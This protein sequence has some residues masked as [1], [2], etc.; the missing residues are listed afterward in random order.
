MSAIMT[1]EEEGD[2]YLYVRR[3]PTK[4]AHHETAIST[5]TPYRISAL[6]RC[7]SVGRSQFS[8]Q[9]RAWRR[10]TD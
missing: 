10:L 3:R 7:R 6:R 4:P 2:K 8:S 5:H 9:R 1:S